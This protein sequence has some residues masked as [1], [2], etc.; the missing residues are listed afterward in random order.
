MLK[1]VLYRG[2]YEGF[3]WKRCPCTVAV[4]TAVFVEEFFF[5]FRAFYFCASDL[6]TL[7]LSLLVAIVEI[8]RYTE[9]E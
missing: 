3:V 7:Q 6:P 5:F 9:T 4:F 1:D 2:S 8:L